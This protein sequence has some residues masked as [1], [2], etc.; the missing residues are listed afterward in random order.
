MRA[1]YQLDI[2]CV[3]CVSNAAFLRLPARCVLAPGAFHASDAFR[4]APSLPRRLGLSP[5]EPM[6]LLLD[7]R[8]EVVTQ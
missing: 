2:L 8:E 1:W 4:L 7:L 3:S 6:L 5:G